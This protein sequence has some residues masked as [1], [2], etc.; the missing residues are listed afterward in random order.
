MTGDAFEH[1]EEAWGLSGNPFPSAAIHDSQDSPYSQEVFGE[2][3]NEFR[4]KLIRGAVQNN[5][6]VSFLWS[7][8]SQV[9]TGFGKTT[10]M[11]EIT[12][13]INCDLGANTLTQAGMRQERQV[14]IA[15]A[16]SNLNNLEA[17][18]LYPVLFNAVLNLTE[19]PDKGNEAVIDKARARIIADIG[20]DEPSKISDHLRDVWL[21]ICGTAGPIRPEL[22]SAFA[23]EGASAVR[24]TLGEVS[25][26]ARLRNG[27]RYLDF[28]LNVLAASG[29]YHLYLM[30]DQLEDLATTRTITKAKRSREIGR[31]RDMLEGHP[32][33]NRVHFIFTFHNQAAQKLAEFWEQNRLPPFDISPNN[34]ASIVVLRG[35]KD[36]EQVRELLRVYLREFRESKV[37]DDLVP[38]E[39]EA[40]GMMR[41]ASEGRV[42]ILLNRAYELLNLAAEQGAPRITGELTR[43]FFEGGDGI[44]PPVPETR[45]D[46]EAGDIDDLLIGTK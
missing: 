42:G 45:P 21:D 14:P 22:I 6:N 30:I 39:P 29:I 8:G 43:K 28:A 4:R 9:D 31:I 20:E 17:S 24:V 18:G 37:D 5:I 13:E 2:E 35:I 32:Y 15:A 11:R 34:T 7:Q 44:S 36:D 46:G 16:Y 25:P 27:L 19:P 3:T 33:A 1:M 23:S 40:I 10:L 38:F 41:E 26:T 12:K